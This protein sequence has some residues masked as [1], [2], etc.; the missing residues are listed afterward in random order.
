M[1]YVLDHAA[2]FFCRDTISR[3]YLRAQRVKTPILEFGPDA[4]LG[5]HLRD[6]EKGDAYRSKAHGLEEGRFICVIPRLR[7]TPYYRIR[8]VARTPADDVRDAI[9]ERTTEQDHAQAPG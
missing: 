8:N 1:R 5:M 2:F 3:D 9:N 4:Q 7:Y 6:D